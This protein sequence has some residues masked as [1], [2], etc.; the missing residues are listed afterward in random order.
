MFHWT[1]LGWYYWQHG[2]RV[3]PVA[4]EEIARLVACG[5]LL[6]TEEV[7]KAWKDANNNVRFFGSQA[8]GL[9]GAAEGVPAIPYARRP[10]SAAPG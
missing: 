5:Q 10:P 7:L 8:D 4:G 1:F 6:A 3:G 9:A 2:E